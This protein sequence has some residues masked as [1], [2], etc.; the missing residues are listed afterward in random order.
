MNEGHFDKE[1]FPTYYLHLF[2][3]SGL[4]YVVRMGRGERY[5]R[6]ASLS[7]LLSVPFSN[8]SRIPPCRY[9]TPSRIEG[10]QF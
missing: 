6:C 3:V 5:M 7:R 2:I 4:I 9:P 10:C 8:R 1:T